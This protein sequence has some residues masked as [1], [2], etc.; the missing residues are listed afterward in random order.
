MFSNPKMAALCLVLVVM[1][2]G[3]QLSNTATTPA[4]NTPTASTRSPTTVPKRSTTKVPTRSYTTAPPR[5]AVTAPSRSIKVSPYSDC[6]PFD[7]T[8][9]SCEDDTVGPIIR[10]S[11]GT[12][13]ID[14]CLSD[15][16]DSEYRTF[17]RLD[18]EEQNPIS[19]TENFLKNVLFEE[20]IISTTPINHVDPNFLGTSRNFTKKNTILL[21]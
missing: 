3:A 4:Q 9:C 21:L 16:S 17:Y 20:I 13:D 12:G 18:M 10:L 6:P 15:L 1:A 5:G 2:L 11:A 8:R 19:L 14:A 7:L